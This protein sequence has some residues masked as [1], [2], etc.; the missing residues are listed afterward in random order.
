MTYTNDMP[1]FIVEGAIENTENWQP[2]SV[3]G[4]L[5]IE[6]AKL[7]LEALKEARPYFAAR[8]KE[9]Y[10]LDVPPVKYRIVK[11]IKTVKE[12]VE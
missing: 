4:D 3:I 9:K 10:N 2:Y 6:M 11:N 5:T 7:T 8:M 1:Y 12:I